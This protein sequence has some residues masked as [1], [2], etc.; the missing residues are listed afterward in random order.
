MSKILSFLAN[1]VVLFL[2]PLIL[3]IGIIIMIA[4][5]LDEYFIPFYVMALIAGYLLVIYIISSRVNPAYKIS[6]IT[7]ILAVPIFGPAF[8]L[9]YGGMRIPKVIR[10]KK[11]RIEEKTYKLLEQDKDIITRMEEKDRMVACQA[12]YIESE[13]FPVYKDT[14]VEYLPTGEIK[15]ERMLEDLRGAK[16]HIFLQ[17]FIIAEGTMWGEILKILEAKAKQGVDV[18]V[19][20]D[21]VGCLPTLPNGYYKTLREKG[22]KCYKIN[23]LVTYK[24][25]T[26][27]QNNRD[28]RKILVVDGHTGY[29]GGINLG[30]EYININSPYGHWRDCAV[31]L[32]GPAVWSLTVI[33]LRNWMIYDDEKQD[34]EKYRADR[35]VKGFQYVKGNIQP[36]S[37][38]PLDFRNVGENVYMN[39]INSA[40]R[41]VF[42]ATPY[43][44]PSHELITCLKLAAERGVDVRIVTP[45]IPDKKSV[46]LLTQSYYKELMESGVKVY[47]YTPGFVHSKTFVADGKVGVCGTINLDFRSLYLHFEDAVWMN[48]CKAVKDMRAD[49]LMQ[50]ESCKEIS[51][52]E[53]N[54]WPVIKKIAQAL[55][56]VFA[57][58]L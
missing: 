40:T 12:K 43:L 29:T 21:D 3:Q 20:Y 41:D 36:Y 45:S 42:I 17:Y 56:K 54:N 47:Q 23:P 31:R 13:G 51:L 38:S 34:F 52:H 5:L 39:V 49:Y 25:F 9:F 8:Y 32:Y 11:A 19:M 24:N 55:M 27:I 2:I 33:F 22:I 53:V 44:I 14:E 46:F 16:H 48:K 37:D 6:W 57:P 15:W 4:M 26:M 35:Y 58:L 28:H 10:I 30:D 1:R 18:R 7:M 50:L